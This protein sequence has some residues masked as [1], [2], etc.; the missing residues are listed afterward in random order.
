MEMNLINAL[1]IFI[2]TA[3]AFFLGILITPIAT[4]FFFKYKMWKGQG[5]SLG[6]GAE[7]RK[8]HD[9]SIELRTPR[10]GGII[11][12]SSVILSTLFFYLLAVLWPTEASLKMNFL[13]RNQTLIPFF[14]LL[15]GAD[16]KTKWRVSRSSK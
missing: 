1:K 2:P 16:K 10:V 4:H 6:A 11:I 13:S 15:L 3:L 9:D 12:W 7:F 5:R 14:T 8:I